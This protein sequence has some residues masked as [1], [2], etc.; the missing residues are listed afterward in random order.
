[1]SRP[2][3]GLLREQRRT[4]RRRRRH[5]RLRLQPAAAALGLPARPSQRA[6]PGPHFAG[7]VR[8][9]GSR[10]R[11]VSSTGLGEGARLLVPG[12][13]WEWGTRRREPAKPERPTDGGVRGRGAR[14][15]AQEAQRRRRH[16][17]VVTGGRFPV[18]RTRSHTH[19]RRKNARRAASGRFELRASLK[20]IPAAF[21]GGVPP[22]PPNR[23]RQRGGGDGRAPNPLPAAA[24]FASSSDPFGAGGRRGTGRVR[25]LLGLRNCCSA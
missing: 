2:R 7:V 13:G 11:R 17:V 12:R 10:S 4:P 15:P 22:G 21:C 9:P 16:P 20:S 25:G 5:L 23:E 14:L 1:M 18:P 8:E 24:P 19:G 6:R 3:S